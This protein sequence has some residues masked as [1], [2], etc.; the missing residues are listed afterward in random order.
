MY[1]YYIHTCIHSQQHFGFLWTVSVVSQQR[2]M[3]A[4]FTWES[5]EVQANTDDPNPNPVLSEYAL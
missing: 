3:E 2:N 4:A 5:R 1:S